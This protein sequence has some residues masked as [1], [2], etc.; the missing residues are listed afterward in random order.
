[1]KRKT[2]EAGAE[3]PQSPKTSMGLIGSCKPP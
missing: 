1:M 3:K 2:P